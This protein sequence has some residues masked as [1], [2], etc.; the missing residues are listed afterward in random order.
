[1]RRQLDACEP[2]A[3]EVHYRRAI[4]FIHQSTIDDAARDL[5]AALAA[6]P[7]DPRV[8]LARV[9]WYER[10]TKIA[11]PTSPP[12]P[13]ELLDRGRVGADEGVGDGVGEP[14]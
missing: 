2:G 5:D 12:A 11:G 3:P 1:V 8:L 9:A 7:D 10:R 13:Q 6:R 4:F 14:R